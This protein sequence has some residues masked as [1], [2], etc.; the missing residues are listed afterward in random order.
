VSECARLIEN[1]LG[2]EAVEAI[3]LCGSFAAGDETV[4]LE[5]DPPIVLSDLDLVVIV[6]SFEDHAAWLKRRVELGSACEALMSDVRF[7]GH[8]EVGVMLAEDLRTLPARPGVY[9]MRERG[10]V[11]RGDSK[12]LKLIPA[13]A[14][15]D[16]TGREALIL[17]EN[18]VIPLI[19]SRHG[20]RPGSDA[21]PYGFLYG[22]ARGYTDI[23][24]AAL[25]LAGAYVPG[26][27]ARS[28]RI[29]AE[30]ER[31]KDGILSRLMRPEL[32]DRIERWTRFK[33]EP[34]KGAA[35]VRMDP[36]V[37]PE[38]W[39][40][41]CRDILF[42]WRQ[43]ATHLFEAR[44]D[45]SK[46]LPFGALTG[47][48]RSLWN[49]RNH[50]R[51]WRAFLSGV[52]APR[53]IVHAAALGSRLL[54]ENPLDIVRE[55]GMRLLDHRL[56][57]GTD[58]PVRGARGGFPYHGGSWESAAAELSSAWNALVFGRMNG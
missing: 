55:E 44:G 16:I 48:G 13:Y 17:I 31:E 54:S 37:S 38:L 14:T 24:A 49:W 5:T 46:P 19:D 45:I 28:S 15:G 35:G 6:T 20:A 42:F 30:T 51:A 58:V 27:A 50:V 23:A 11:L 43:A 26:Y 4:V 39:E 9:D 32:V 29:R 21:E 36:R 53:R 18:R 57:H 8:V 22:I 3:C 47:R 2:G 41:A 12:I 52:P 40:D 25:S 34:S 33:L 56:S 1:R 7:S 10:R